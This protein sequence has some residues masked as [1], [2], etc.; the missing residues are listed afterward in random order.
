[1]R[2]GQKAPAKD[3]IRFVKKVYKVLANRKFKP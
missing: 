1:M 3:R 2:F